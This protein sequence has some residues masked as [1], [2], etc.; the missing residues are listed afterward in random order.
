M[1]NKWKVVESGV[2]QYFFNV[3]CLNGDPEATTMQE[4]TKI[5]YPFR[6]EVKEPSSNEQFSTEVVAIKLLGFDLNNV[7]HANLLEAVECLVHHLRDKLGWT[8]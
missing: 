8:V 2:H 5:N 4:E 7:L 1:T 6:V 3:V